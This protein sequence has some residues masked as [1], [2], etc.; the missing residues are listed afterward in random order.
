MRIKSKS[1]LE[2]MDRKLRFQ[3]Y[4]ETSIRTYI[5]YTRLFLSDFNKDI[6]H[7][8]VKE[9]EEWL[10]NYPYSSRSQQNQIISSVKFLYSNIVGRKL[11]TLKIKRPRKQKKIPR[12]IDAESLAIKIKRIPNLKHRAILTLGLSCG[13]RISEV[14]N[15][16]WE[17][18]NRERNLLYVINGKGKKDR[19]IPLNESTIKLLEDYWRAYR[20]K[21]YVFNG[22]FSLQYSQTS[23]QKIVKKYIHHKA[24]FHLLRHAFATYAIDNGTELK[25]LSVSMGHNSTKTVERFYFHQSDR[26][27]K[28]IKQAI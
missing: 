23:I 8:S 3:N 18:L 19:S 17:H 4:A 5:S 12:V 6:Y 14:I 21:D 22:Q 25:P 27:L 9:A 28:T 7:I 20:S 10:L 26:T 1:T 16:K 2:K 11:N 15:L 24:S 13:L